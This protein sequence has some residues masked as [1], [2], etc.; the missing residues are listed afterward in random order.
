MLEAKVY[1]VEVAV[2]SVAFAVFGLWGMRLWGLL[3]SDHVKSWF[4]NYSAKGRQ[5]I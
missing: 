2:W 1:K 3:G 5:R 4:G